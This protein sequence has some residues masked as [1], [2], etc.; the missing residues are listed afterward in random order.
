MLADV[1]SRVGAEAARLAQPELD[2]VDRDYLGA[3]RFRD[4]HRMQ[5]ESA[6]AEHQE[7]L[8][9]GKARAVEAPVHLRHRAVGGRGDRIRHVVRDAIEMLVWF[10]EVMRREGRG[11]VRR[12]VGMARAD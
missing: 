8:A 9:V 3:A 7:L 4:R 5:T 10:Y 6:G 11:E 12:F 1:D 2:G